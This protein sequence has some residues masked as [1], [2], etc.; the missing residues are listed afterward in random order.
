[1]GSLDTGPPEFR[2]QGM[3]GHPDPN[4]G[5][6][7]SS[8]N[9]AE[10]VGILVGRPALV[11]ELLALTTRE[12]RHARLLS[13]GVVDWAYRPKND[14]TNGSAQE[15]VPPGHIATADGYLIPMTPILA[16]ASVAL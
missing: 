3:T 10:I 16:V 9:L 6:P 5:A 2:G 13:A 15:L 11:E 8:P 14:P 4:Q 1:M 7:A 12:E